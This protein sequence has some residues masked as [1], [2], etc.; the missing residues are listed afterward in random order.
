[1]TWSLDPLT[2]KEEKLGVRTWLYDVLHPF[3]SSLPVP[4]FSENEKERNGG[5]VLRAV[6]FPCLEKD[7]KSVKTLQALRSV[8]VDES[9]HEEI[10][11][12]DL[13][14]STVE[15]LFKKVREKDTS[16]VFDELLGTP[17]SRFPEKSK[18]GFHVKYYMIDSTRVS[19]MLKN[20]IPL[21]LDL[22][23]SRVSGVTVPD[24]LPQEE[25][26]IIEEV[27]FPT[28]V[29]EIT[30]W[31][32]EHF[33]SDDESDDGSSTEAEDIED[34]EQ[35]LDYDVQPRRRLPDDVWLKS[36]LQ[37]GEFAGSS[38]RFNQPNEE[39]R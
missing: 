33:S 2:S 14:T 35:K 3:L 27:N 7:H 32:F 10:R 6:P 8:F 22:V 13:S 26:V 30:K 37:I 21:V 16:K 4:G 23:K 28:Q 34:E 11:V 24:Q 25:D 39:T 31:L 12:E 38:P 18:V 9:K 17:F 5:L 29:G 36:I 15:N 19:W 20:T 1:L